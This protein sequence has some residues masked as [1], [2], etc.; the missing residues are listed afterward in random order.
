ML[1][2]L[3]TLASCGGSVTQLMQNPTVPLIG[4]N[5]TLGISYNLNETVTSG[6]AL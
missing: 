6:T 2:L 1:K 5:V 3:T 4:D